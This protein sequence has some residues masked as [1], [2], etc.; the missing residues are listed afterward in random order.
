MVLHDDTETERRVRNSMSNISYTG[1][2]IQRSKVHFRP[3]VSA[4]QASTHTQTD[5]V[6]PPPRPPHHPPP[7]IR[8]PTSSS[9]PLCTYVH[10]RPRPR[11]WVV[12]GP[13]CPRPWVSVPC[14]W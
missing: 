5:T 6:I 4:F 8:P 2:T 12:R 14:P 13:C 10:V 11:S 7:Y 1:H 9:P 3:H